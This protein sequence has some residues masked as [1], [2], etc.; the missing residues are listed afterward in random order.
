MKRVVW[1][2]LAA[3]VL[4]L[5][6]YS[7]VT[8]SG[9]VFEDK[10]GNGV[11]DKG[12]KGIR[13]VCV[14]NG[15]TVVVT[16]RDGGFSINAGVGQGIFP[17]LPSGYGFAGGAV[18]N[19]NFRYVE[20]ASDA[21]GT[22]FALVSRPAKTSF[23]VAAVGDVQ[24]IDHNELSFANRT[25]FAELA[26]RSDIDFGIV[27]GDMVNDKPELFG[28]IRDA[29]EKMPFGS[30][31]VAGNHD[32]AE[33]QQRDFDAY[34]RMFKT[35]D[36]A[37]CYG[38]VY[39]LVFN[40]IQP[41]N[42]VI[43]GYRGY[44][45]ERQKRFLQ[46]MLRVIPRDKLIVISQHIPLCYYRDREEIV[47]MLGERKVLVLSA[48]AHRVMKFVYAGNICEQVVGSPCGMFW[49]GERGY[50]AIPG[51]LQDCGSPRNYFTVDFSGTDYTLSYKGI[52][53][54]ASVQSHVWIKGEEEVDD[55][56]EGFTD[57]TQGT[58][59]ANIFGGGKE[60][61]VEMSV[62]GGEW[63]AMEYADIQAPSSVRMR[64]W[65]KTA[66][67]PTKYSRLQPMRTTS[68]PHIWRAQLP[69][70]IKSGV[71]S[72]S[73]RAKDDHGLDIR[74]ERVFYIAE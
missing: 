46:N 47:D 16:S 32:R 64:Y 13:N 74:Q 28:D 53:M 30:W 56:A 17:V 72:I 24:V 68:S 21:S 14:S 62:N 23:R 40:N 27:L 43:S 61:L 20:N 35:G 31:T 29:V 55:G 10:N 4:G 22:D 69:G 67:Y 51:A 44:L 52:G 71:H 37:F 1:L 36:Y 48:H 41:D 19:T 45:T 59:I 3:V 50:D 42:T 70:D 18:Y 8:V 38:D 57:I 54:D 65:N 39:F 26:G 49:R 73:V 5:N 12:E 15:D 34:N 7:Q 33:K 60:T 9:V 58:V 6:S 63:Q 11:R 66:D 2:I 25:V